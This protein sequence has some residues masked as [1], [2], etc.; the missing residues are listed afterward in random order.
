MSPK[1][2]SSAQRCIACRDNASAIEPLKY[3]PTLP[4]S[5]TM[6]S[7]MVKKRRSSLFTEKAPIRTE[8]LPL[9]RLAPRRYSAGFLPA[10]QEKAAGMTPPPVCVAAH[11][12]LRS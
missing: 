2:A 11:D 9:P 7:A 12:G 6:P 10:M 1:P 3:N 8:G 5:A 4:N